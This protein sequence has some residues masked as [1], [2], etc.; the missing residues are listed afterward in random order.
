MCPL[1]WPPHQV[2]GSVGGYARGPRGS[3]L[4]WRTQERQLAREGNLAS[5]KIDE[6]CIPRGGIAGTA[7]SV[8]VYLTRCQT[9]SF[10]LGEIQS[11]YVDFE[12]P[13]LLTV[14]NNPTNTYPTPKPSHPIRNQA[15]RKADVDVDQIW[16]DNLSEYSVDIPHQVT[17]ADVHVQ[18]GPVRI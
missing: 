16:T 14:R 8:Q 17:N 4:L 9:H 18:Q 13:R 10:W 2:D 3:R 7:T 15:E 12:L 1:A 5:R 6:V 11:C